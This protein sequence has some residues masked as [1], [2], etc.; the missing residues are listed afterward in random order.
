[1]KKLLLFLSLILVLSA[2]GCVEP[3][4]RVT[5]LKTADQKG[6]AFGRVAPVAGITEGWIGVRR[7]DGAAKKYALDADGYF[8]IKAKAGDLELTQLGYRDQTGVVKVDFEKPFG[9]TVAPAGV[10]YVGLI[11]VSPIGR[12]VQLTDDFMR[13][14]DWYLGQ[15]GDE[16]KPASAFANQAYYELM[17][18]YLHAPLPPVKREGERVWI[19][20]TAFLMG[21]VM[22][23][24]AVTGP[25]GGDLTQLPPRELQV[26]GFWIDRLPVTQAALSRAGT[27]A[28]DR[29]DWNE[30]R[31]YCEA[32]GG[33]LPTEVEY[34]LAAR[35]PRWGARYYA[36]APAMTAVANVPRGALPDTADPQGWKESPGGALFQAAQ[37]AEWTGSSLPD[38]PLMVVRAGPYRF[39]L[40]PEA[41]ETNV[42]FRCV[43]G[44][45][46]EATMLP[47]AGQK[48]PEAAP[49]GTSDEAPP[50]REKEEYDAVIRV[51]CDLFA[52]PSYE[53]AVIR[54]LTAGSGVLILGRSEDFY[55]VRVPN[56]DEG[57]V[58]ASKVSRQS[59][60]MR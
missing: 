38:R 47:G 39:A 30:A 36:G 19:P 21:E 6:I 45:S 10:T 37:L 17:Q 4:P 12:N 29:V 49:S 48:A 27:A 46:P 26:E 16:L 13:D 15:Y 1:M 32:R 31:R 50:S 58:E 5:Y 44:G 59:G 56:L 35:G 55:F 43:Y 24:N 28:A 3:L 57:F 53:A 23:G 52:G 42:G 25:G 40:A 22:P 14:R 51:D 8:L 33:R 60:E 41:M 7:A 2:F 18:T 34:E 9:F 20:T 11:Y 54:R